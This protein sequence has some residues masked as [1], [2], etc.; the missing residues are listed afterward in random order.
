MSQNRYSD[1]LA[2]IRSMME[3]SSR[4]LSLSGWAGIL[5]GIFAL[6]G[7]SIAVWC[8]RQ[9]SPI[10]A[11]LGTAWQQYCTRHT[12]IKY[13]SHRAGSVHILFLVYVPAESHER[14]IK[15]SGRPPSAICCCIFLSPWW[16]E[17][18]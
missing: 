17:P 4:F 6:A 10:R 9:A 8:I 5:P 16:P 1:D 12:A 14:K 18:S 7:L 11:I 2:H 15:L 3:R 13:C